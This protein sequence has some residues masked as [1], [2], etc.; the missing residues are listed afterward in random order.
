MTTIGRRPMKKTILEKTTE[1][2]RTGH[3]ATVY[4]VIRDPSLKNRDII[5][6]S[7]EKVFPFT[8]GSQY[9]G[10]WQVDRKE[11][12][13]IQINHDDTKYIGE[14]QSNFYHG[15]GTLWAKI[16]S[17]STL[18]GQQ[19]KYVRRYVGDWA[20]GAMEGDGV[21]YYENGEIYKGGWFKN[22]RH[23]TGRMEFNNDS[24]YEGE[25]RN[26]LRDGFGVTKFSNGN[27]H[28]GIWSKD[29]K[30]GPGIFY[31]ASTRKMYQGEW[32]DD[33]PRCGEYRPLTIEE[34]ERFNEPLPKGLYAN[35]FELPSLGL[36]NPNLIINVAVSEVRVNSL[37][38]SSN[39]DLGSTISIIPHEYLERA[40]IVFNNIVSK[41]SDTIPIFEL[42]PVFNEFGLQL[43]TYDINEIIYQLELKD[44]QE[45]TFAE[46]VEIAS[47]IKR[48][49]E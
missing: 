11:G 6:N 48:E 47:F 23:G 16:T 3:H 31:Y 22:K 36:A 24:I 39:Q 5:R 20:N 44:T 8:N 42:Q 32:F 34:S 33:Q 25:W 10:E 17:N 1:S 26:D 30:E 18:K 43:N 21:Y 37:K 38:Q 28:E 2:L 19:K 14:W 4:E 40:N 15:K 29:M 7:N 41:G 27:V 49:T 45:I 35:E 9:K 13:G 46:V 12:F